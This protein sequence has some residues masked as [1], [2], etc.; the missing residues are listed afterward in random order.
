MHVCMYE[1]EQCFDLVICILHFQATKQYNSNNTG[2][3][4]TGNNVVF[5]SANLRLLSIC[6]DNLFFV[7]CLLK[8][9]LVFF[10]GF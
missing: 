7:H 1:I 2:D 10:F 9:I 5:F 8:C 4:S 6:W 3:I